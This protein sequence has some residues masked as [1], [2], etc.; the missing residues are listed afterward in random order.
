MDAARARTRPRAARESRASLA[1][2]R[3]DRCERARRTSSPSRRLARRESGERTSAKNPP[4]KK[5]PTRRRP[6]RFV[7]RASGASSVES[8]T[9]GFENGRVPDDGKGACPMERARARWKGRRVPDGKGACAMET[10]SSRSGKS[11]ESASD[12]TLNAETT[13]TLSS[14]L[15]SSQTLDPPAPGVAFAET[16]PRDVFA[17]PLRGACARPVSSDFIGASLFS[18]SL[19]TTRASTPPS[20]PPSDRVTCILASA[21]PRSAPRSC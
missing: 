21:S 1:R 20:P 13:S 16:S 10:R 11:R 3:R 5:T 17:S 6:P 12:G 8:Q 14:S 2:R 18:P 15:S 7:R 4:R 9:T 19:T